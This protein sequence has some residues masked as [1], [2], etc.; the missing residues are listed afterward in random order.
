M[1]PETANLGPNYLVYLTKTFNRSFIRTYNL[2]VPKSYLLPK[3]YDDLVPTL[4]KIIDD[5]WLPRYA[6][7][8]N[9]D[10]IALPGAWSPNSTLFIFYAGVDDAVTTFYN[11]ATHQLPRNEDHAQARIEAYVAALERIYNAGGRNFL[12]IGIPALEECPKIRTADIPR[13]VSRF[14]AEEVDM[15]ARIAFGVQ[16]FAHRH[17]DATVW[18][19]NTLKMSTRA[20]TTPFSGFP[21]L[22]G[23]TRIEGY[24]YPYAEKDDW[25]IGEHGEVWVWDDL[26]RDPLNAFYWRDQ[27]H[28]TGPWHRLL[29]RLIVELL[30][31]KDGDARLPLE[32]Y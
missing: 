21:E 5:H 26:C 2:A 14:G 4:S 20:R 12:I 18:I 25:P 27:T 29:G 1:Y 16:M 19:F 23:V 17:L 30:D 7:L 24:C 13:S 22:S 6:P 3:E 28:M 32:F 9:R 10:P 11:E 8:K 15:N 31:G